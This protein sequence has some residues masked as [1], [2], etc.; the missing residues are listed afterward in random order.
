MGV[1]AILIGT[2]KRHRAG[3]GGDAN[4]RYEEG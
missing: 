1:G 3:D 4:E 2:G